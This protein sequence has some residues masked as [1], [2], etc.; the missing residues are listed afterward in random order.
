MRCAFAPPAQSATLLSSDV[1]TATCKPCVQA[2]RLAWVVNNPL[3]IFLSL[4]KKAGQER[5]RFTATRYSAMRDKG[6][7]KSRRRESMGYKL[8]VFLP[9]MPN[10]KCLTGLQKQSNLTQSHLNSA[11]VY[12][13]PTV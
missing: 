1:I 9:R 13:A 6:C 11:R 7:Y 3:F 4:K 12:R 10:N 5:G 8:F 2:L